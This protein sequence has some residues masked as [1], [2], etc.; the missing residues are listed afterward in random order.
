MLIERRR[1]VLV[2]SILLSALGSCLFFRLAEITFDLPILIP[3][4]VF[5]T[6]LF[7]GFCFLWPFLGAAIIEMNQ[8]LMGSSWPKPEPL[9]KFL[10]GFSLVG[11]LIAILG[12]I[13]GDADSALGIPGSLGLL[14]GSC[15]YLGR[16]KRESE[17]D[18][19]PSK[20]E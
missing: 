6:A 19:P 20:I 8:R 5:A 1:I 18:A 16:T 4:F 7:Y 14:A 17:Q 11:V 2:V 13:A 3:F 15:Y 9:A 10:L 12:I